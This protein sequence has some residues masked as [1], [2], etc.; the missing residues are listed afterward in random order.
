MIP[1]LDQLDHI[2]V[3]Y[4]GLNMR[5]Q[6]ELNYLKR[7]SPP[8]YKSMRTHLVLSSLAKDSDLIDSAKRYEALGFNDVIFTALDE[9]NVHGNIYN[10]I[11]KIKTELFAFGIGPKVPEDFEKATPERVA[12][13]ILQITQTVQAQSSQQDHSL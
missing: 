12:D 3:D 5:S 10:F 1:H 8:V 2:L 4:A 7:M 11:R 13:L 9:A 6:E